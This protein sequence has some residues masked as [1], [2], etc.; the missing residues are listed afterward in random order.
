MRGRRG[1]RFKT[2]CH[3]D[4][5]MPGAFRAEGGPRWLQSRQPAISW[6]D[7]VICDARKDAITEVSNGQA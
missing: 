2:E 5:S 7:R 6:S 1:F 3:H 4:G